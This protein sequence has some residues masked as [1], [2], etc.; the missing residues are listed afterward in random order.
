[1]FAVGLAIPLGLA[2][3]LANAGSAAQP[4]TPAPTVDD[5]DGDRVYVERG[6]LGLI[7]DQ[8]PCHNAV[9]V[10]EARFRSSRELPVDQLLPKASLA[11]TG[12]LAQTWLCGSTSTLL[13]Y[14]SGIDVFSENNWTGI[15][16]I[17]EK[18]QSMI[19]Q[20]NEVI[21]GSGGHTESL[22]GTTALV[23]PPDRPGADTERPGSVRFVEN[24]TLVTVSGTPEISVEQLLSVAKSLR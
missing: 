19:A 18:W 8:G 22:R 20:S 21:P 14:D 1:M 16:D 10:S 15:P 23:L 2:V 17:A 12:D 4:R 7:E 9:R 24:Q 5:P 6:P 3:G 13:R 11:S